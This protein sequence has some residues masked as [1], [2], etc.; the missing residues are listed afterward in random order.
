MFKIL[1][2][3]RYLFQA[4][5]QITDAGKASVKLLEEQSGPG[6]FLGLLGKLFIDN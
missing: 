6:L 4:K 1:G 3:L 5:N 2:H